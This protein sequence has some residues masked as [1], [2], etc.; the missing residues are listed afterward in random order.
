[1]RRVSRGIFREF[2]GAFF[3]FVPVSVLVAMIVIRPF[4][5]K[6]TSV[7]PE[8]IDGLLGTISYGFPYRAVKQWVIRA[9]LRFLK[10]A[11]EVA[12]KEVIEDAKNR[13]G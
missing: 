5:S 2:L 11:V 13:D 7:P 8:A 4:L 3:I 9:S 12:D 1:M 10:E 6:L